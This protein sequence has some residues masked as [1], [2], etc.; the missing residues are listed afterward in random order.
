MFMYV[1]PLQ[2]RYVLELSVMLV[3]HLPAKGHRCV[4]V[5]VL[6]KTL[7]QYVVGVFAKRLDFCWRK[8]SVLLFSGRK[9]L[10]KL[11]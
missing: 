5:I 8:Q 7:E 3:L 1:L 11:C 10:L 4:F 6:F 2:Q 9:N